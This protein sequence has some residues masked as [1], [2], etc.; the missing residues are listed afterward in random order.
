MSK[1][2]LA[3]V[4]FIIWILP[5]CGCVAI[6]ILNHPDAFNRMVVW[7]HRGKKKSFIINVENG[8]G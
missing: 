2:T 3:T 1:Q 7:P 4:I 6:L 5:F 8:G